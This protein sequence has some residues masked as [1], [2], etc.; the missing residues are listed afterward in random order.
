M[1]KICLVIIVIIAIG[2]YSGTWKNGNL[3]S[4]NVGMSLAEKINW[5]GCN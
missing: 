3:C 5:K 4:N 2:Y 1:Y